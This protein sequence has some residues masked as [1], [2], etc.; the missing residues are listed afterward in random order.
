MQARDYEGIIGAS[1][2]EIRTLLL[3]AANHGS[4]SCLSPQAVFEEIEALL[5]N[6]AFYAFLNAEVE[7]GFFDH[8]AFLAEVKSFYLA[9]VNDEL[10]DSMG[11]APDE[12]YGELFSR[13]VTHISHWVKN[14]RIM[15]EQTGALR[16][17]DQGL[18][19]EIETTLV[20]EGEKPE[21]FRRALIA[22]IGARA[23][24]FPDETPD[25]AELFRHHVRKLRA[26]FYEGRRHELRKINEAFLKYADDEDRK[27]LESGEIARVEAMLER[28][29]S[30]YGYTLASARDAVAMVLKTLYKDD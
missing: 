26:A 27:T 3:N 2:R 23:L 20:P 13:Y 1:A 5:E 30:R 25:Y 6:K 22:T 17:P 4:F 18:M 28:L 8:K 10:C 15:D 24:E 12:S 14:S 19:K 11:L 9:N 29:Q 16:D 7:N 21:D